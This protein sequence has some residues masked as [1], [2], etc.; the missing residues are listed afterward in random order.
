MQWKNTIFFI[1]IFFKFKTKIQIHNNN[2]FFQFSLQV[3]SVDKKKLIWVRF[4]NENSCLLTATLIVDTVCVYRLP[5]R[6]DLTR[7]FTFSECT[8]QQRLCHYCLVPIRP[9]SRIMWLNEYVNENGSW[10]QNEAETKEE[11][12]EHDG[13]STDFAILFFYLLTLTASR[14]SLSLRAV[15]FANEYLCCH[16]VCSRVCSPVLRFQ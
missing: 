2:F 14:Y 6:I 16:I 11:G 4:A 3:W 9:S 1:P 15:R 12:E 7:L 5:S 8:T 10:K 13:A